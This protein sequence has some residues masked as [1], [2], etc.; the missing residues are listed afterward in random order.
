MAD[1]AFV[2]IGDWIR[3]QRLAGTLPPNQLHRTPDRG[4]CPRAG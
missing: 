2:R 4:A 3:A 1:N